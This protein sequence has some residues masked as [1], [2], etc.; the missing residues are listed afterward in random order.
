[1]AE[2]IDEAGGGVAKVADHRAG[3]G[4]LAGSAAIEQRFADNV[5]IDHD[6]VER[7]VHRGQHVVVGHQRGLGAHL[8]EAFFIGTNDGQ[9]FDRV[10]QT[11]GEF[12]VLN[13]HAFNAFHM[14]VFLGNPEAI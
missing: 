11:A 2:A 6:S 12:D 1:M 9:Q 7:A 13:A 14:H 4:V 10:S 5:A 3:G 8:D